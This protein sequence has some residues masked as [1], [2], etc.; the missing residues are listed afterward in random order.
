MI[1]IFS[2]SIK[3]DEIWRIPQ[4]KEK[5]NK[6][7][8]GNWMWNGS[9]TQLNTKTW[10]SMAVA[11]LIVNCISDFLF[12]SF[13]LSLNS[14]CVEIGNPPLRRKPENRPIN[15]EN[16]FEKHENTQFKSKIWLP[17][18]RFTANYF[19]WIS[20]KNKRKKNNVKH[21]ARCT[22]YR[23]KWYFVETVWKVELRP[24]CTKSII[25]MRLLWSFAETQAQ[26][27]KICCANGFV[28]VFCK[29]MVSFK[30]FPFGSTRSCHQPTELANMVCVGASFQMTIRNR[31]A[32]AV[33]RSSFLI[34][35]NGWRPT[36]KPQQ[37]EWLEIMDKFKCFVVM[38]PRRVLVCCMIDE[39]GESD[40]CVRT[41]ETTSSRKNACTVIGHYSVPNVVDLLCYWSYSWNLRFWQSDWIS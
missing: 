35:N 36:N 9:D 33:I 19:K 18:P 8:I 26:S 38:E 39:D 12:S 41:N 2:G 17:M 28:L 31:Y 14:L 24:H 5:M 21:L 20:E 32:F 27:C 25:E 29:A 13:Q 7:K 37:T 22:R 3:M 34:A 4:T 16:V 11:M 15:W 30:S 40:E 10:P 23:L 1:S 6:M